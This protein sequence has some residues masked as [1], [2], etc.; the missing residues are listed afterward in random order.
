MRSDLTAPHR[1]APQ[2]LHEQ[3]AFDASVSGEGEA[4][5]YCVSRHLTQY[6]R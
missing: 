3:G 6:L 4:I 5:L 1:T 2:N